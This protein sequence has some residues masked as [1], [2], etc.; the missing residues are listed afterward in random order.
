ML[1]RY[2]RNHLWVRQFRTVVQLGTTDYT[3]RSKVQRSRSQWDHGQIRTFSPI[4]GIRG[5][6]LMKLI[7]ITQYHHL[8]TCDSDDSF[9]IMASELKVTDTCIPI[10]HLVFVLPVTWVRR[11][12]LRQKC[13]RGSIQSSSGKWAHEHFAH[14]FGNFYSG[15]R[16]TKRLKFVLDF[17]HTRLWVALFSKGRCMSEM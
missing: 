15:G 11:A 17:D 8:V 2:L 1:T 5:L 16:G 3:L 9:K 6:I 14:L 13:I 4:S 7:A 12:D 10:N